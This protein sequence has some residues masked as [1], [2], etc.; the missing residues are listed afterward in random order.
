MASTE[1]IDSM[2]GYELASTIIENNL[3]SSTC[4]LHLLSHLLIV[5]L[6]LPALLLALYYINEWLVVWDELT[7]YRTVPQVITEGLIFLNMFM[8]FLVL[9]SYKTT[10]RGS[11]FLMN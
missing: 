2:L 1:D 6:L 11:A 3:L 7:L 10:P 5:S 4:S 9:T 8:A